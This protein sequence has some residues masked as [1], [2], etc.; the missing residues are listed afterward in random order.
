MDTDSEAFELNLANHLK[1]SGYLYSLISLCGDVTWSYSDFDR[2][3]F[4]CFES[5]APRRSVW[6][7]PCFPLVDIERNTHGITQIPLTSLGN[8][9]GIHI[10]VVNCDFTLPN[11]SL[12]VIR[13][14]TVHI[15]VRPRYQSL[16][17]GYWRYSSTTQS[18]PYRL[19]EIK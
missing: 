10:K 18:F 9:K 6:Q 8:I 7:P 12:E 2:F 3:E 17:L 11:L 5:L 14:T 16:Q 4:K 19:S 1:L 15:I 13:D